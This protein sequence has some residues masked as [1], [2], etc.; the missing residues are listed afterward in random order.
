MP[1]PGSQSG[2]RGAPELGQSGQRIA[3]PRVLEVQVALVH[4]LRARG[5]TEAAQALTADV[6]PLLQG[7]SSAYL[8]DLRARPQQH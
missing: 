4:G 6:A 5:Q 7:P 3:D 2:G 1:S 8:V